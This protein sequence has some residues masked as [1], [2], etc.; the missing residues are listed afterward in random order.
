MGSLHTKHSSQKRVISQCSP[1]DRHDGCG[2]SA[3]DN[4]EPLATIVSRRNAA[5]TTRSSP[6]HSLTTGHECK[7]AARETIPCVRARTAPSLMLIRASGSLVG[8]ADWTILGIPVPSHG[9]HSRISTLSRPP[10]LVCLL[11]DECTVAGRC[12]CFDAMRS[13]TCLKRLH[14]GTQWSF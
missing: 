7:H 10:P 5:G 3:T 9:C 11:G 4:Q 6:V 1:M 2:K 8:V 14:P 13:N 12:T